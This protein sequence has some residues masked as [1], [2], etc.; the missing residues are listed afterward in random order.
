MQKKILVAVDGSIHTK[1]AIRY[2]ARLSSMVE[3]IT[4]ELIHIQPAVSQ[5]LKEDADQSRLKA[6]MARQATQ[7]RQLLEEYKDQMLRRDVTESRIILTTLPRQRGVAEDV[8]NFGQNGRYDAVLIG[9][10]GASYLTELML[11]SVTANLIAHTQVIPIWMVDGDVASDKILVAVDGSEG[12]LR[13]VDHLSFILAGQTDVQLQFV[14]VEPRL[15]DYCDID[16]NDPAAADTTEVSLNENRRCIDRFYA[17]AR[18]IMQEAGFSEKQL[19]IKVVKS[20][21]R[22]GKAVVDEARNGDY[23]TVVIGRHGQGRTVF[24]G[25]VAR[26]VIN[27]ATE[28]AL[29]IVP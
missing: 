19:D 28:R 15:G 9:R 24:G 6:V 1:Q 11:G 16:L 3:D 10:R 17:Q 2:A 26:Y 20:M 13:A 25:S 22:T 12:S 29:W 23:G 5:Y 14:H 27:K 18:A 7:A 8:L 4:Y 21:M